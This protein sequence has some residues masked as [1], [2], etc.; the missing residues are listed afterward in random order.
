MRMVKNNKDLNLRKKSPRLKKP[1]ISDEIVST[2][3]QYFSVKLHP[4]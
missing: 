2:E 1:S 3:A 4:S